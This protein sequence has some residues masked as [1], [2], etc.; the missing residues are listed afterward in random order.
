MATIPP[1]ILNRRSPINSTETTLAGAATFTGAGEHVI[2]FE[3]IE[4]QV[5][6]DVTGTLEVQF[7]N[8]NATWTQAAKSFDIRPNVTE[9]FYAG[10]FGVYA[11]IVYTNGATPQ[12]LFALTTSL[13]GTT[14]PSSAI[15][16]RLETSVSFDK[17]LVDTF[18]RIRTSMPFTLF[19]A[20]FLTTSQPELFAELNTAGTISYTAG[21]SYV[22]LS[23]PLD[24]TA[25]V[26]RQSNRYIAYQPG[27]SRIAFL[28]GVLEIGGGAVGS[29]SRIGVFDD[30]ADKVVDTVKSGDGFFFELAGTE[31]RVVSRSFVTGTPQ[32]DTAIA[33]ADWNIDK[34]D[35][36]GNSG[37]TIDPS[38][39][40]VFVIEQEWLGVGSVIMGVKFGNDIVRC[41]VFHHANRT[42]DTLDI[43]PYNTRATLPV[44]YELSHAA[45]GAATE[46]RQMSNTIISEG[47]FQP[48]STL[49][50]ANTGRTARPFDQTGAFAIMAL[51][52][53]AAA[54]RAS[55]FVYDFSTVVTSN[56]YTLVEILYFEPFDETGT[57]PL[58]AASWTAADAP[59]LM[60]YDISATGID[61]TN[62]TFPYTLLYSTYITQ[63]QDQQVTTNLN[64]AIFG[65]GD[66]AGNRGLIVLTATKARQNGG[67]TMSCSFSWKEFE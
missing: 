42:V 50:S 22:A 14:D 17:S 64:N 5:L 32:V 30:E 37:R 47:G 40:Q 3:E 52:P 41:H 11:R 56:A 21:N 6:S 65:G 19:D 36:T 1:I 43:T 4:V 27:K 61:L 20:S 58:T 34:L 8:D 33:Q 31:L 7:S 12:T 59:S 54:T 26:V 57:S 53:S 45:T 51:R 10:I 24:T 25:K 46:M 2:Q 63:Q 49:Y 55:F 28:A 18:S 29:T 60:E 62:T 13:K 39:R 66:I 48:F 38:K 35:G 67:E 15:T 44:R 9:I 23:A 16:E